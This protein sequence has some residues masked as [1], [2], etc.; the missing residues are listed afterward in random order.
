[1]LWIRFPGVSISGQHPLHDIGRGRTWHKWK[2]YNSPAP[3]LDLMLADDIVRPVCSLYKKVR[4]NLQD[5]FEGRVLIEQANK[6]D[7]LEAVNKLGAFRPWDNGP[8]RTFHA[9]N[10]SVTVDCNDQGIA[11]SARAPK[12]FNM[13]GMQDVKASISENDLFARSS[14]LVN[15]PCDLLDG[16]NHTT[17][18]ASRRGPV[19]FGQNPRRTRI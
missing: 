10:R 12:N 17:I 9:S 2:G 5:R 11:Q 7:H 14:Q 13:A 6:V 1:M 19:F 16:C 18:I 8:V 4:M 15:P 3:A